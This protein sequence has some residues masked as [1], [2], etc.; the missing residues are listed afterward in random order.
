MLPN[1]RIIPPNNNNNNINK[2][3]RARSNSAV[4]DN[5]TKKGFMSRLLTSPNNNN[6]NGP[7]EYNTTGANRPKYESVL[8]IQTKEDYAAW[9]TPRITSPDQKVSLMLFAMILP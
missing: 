5:S 1:S 9:G 7:K 6:N 8:G 2:N 4:N 3:L